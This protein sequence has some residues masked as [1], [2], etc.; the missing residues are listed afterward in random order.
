VTAAPRVLLA[1]DHP[2][3]R[4]GVRMALERGGFEV[5]SEVATAQDAVEAALRER[6]D[7]CLL[8]VNMPG[9]G[10]SAASNITSRLPHT[11]VLM[12]TVSREGDDLLESMRRGASGYLL[13]D[14][15]PMKLP[16][17]VR[18]AMAGEAP[19]PRRMTGFLIEELR[20]DEHHRRPPVTE[21]GRAELT[22]R[23]WEVLDLLCDGA[24]TAEI[25]DR[26]FLSRVTVRRHVSAILRKL[27]VSSRDEAVQMVGRADNAPP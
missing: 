25:A 11:V 17:V 7:V 5:C 22:K 9:G 3:T 10:A 27:G 23:E 2:P 6:P 16:E 19:L 8:D 15:N 4:A 18:A 13:K 14:M 24:G 20:H 21:D 1:D 12:L 26:L